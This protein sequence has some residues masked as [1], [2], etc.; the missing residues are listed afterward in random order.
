MMPIYNDVGVK[1]YF[2]PYDTGLPAQD[3]AE[4]F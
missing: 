3:I 2:D 1:K 4:I